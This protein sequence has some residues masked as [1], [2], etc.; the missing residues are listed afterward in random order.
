MNPIASAVAPA[1]R[2]RILT[3]HV[4]GNYLHALGH[5]PHDFVV[6]GL[7]GDPAGYGA[8]GPRIPWG[9]NLTQLPAGELRAQ[10][11]DC[12][13]YQS[14]QN[15]ED[16]RLLL[17]DAQ[18]ALPC[19]YLEHNPPAPHPTDT[20]HP[21]RHDRGVLVHVT[22]FNAEMWDNGGMPVRVVEHGV[23]LP[24]VAYDGSLAR[25]IVVVNHLARRGRR[26]GL[27][28]FERM[29]ARTPLDLIGME[30]ETLGGLGEVPNME[31]A[32]CLAR[33]RYFFSP[34]RYASLGLSLVE[35]MLCG[36][37]VVGFG[38]TELPALIVNG[39]NGFVDTRIER[40]AQVA[41]QLLA[42]PDLARAWG[43]AGRE[44]ALRRF[45]MDRFVADW[46]AVFEQL[47]EAA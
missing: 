8:L 20:V 17:S 41:R 45:G 38:T 6:P 19:A 43:A 18:R 46:L 31:V 36:V 15:L 25:G 22:P 2:L 39:E 37:P 7:P 24:G 32:A 29:R 12:V 10:R 1:R 33:Y 3:W 4:H 21:F 47:T 27:D 40:L 35:A 5:V 44:T 34:V 30:S 16:A 26:I 13:L 28:L 11:F 42:E 9:D 23:P 14:R